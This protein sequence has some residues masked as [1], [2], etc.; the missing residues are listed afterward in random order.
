MMTDCWMENPG[1][2]PN[3]TQVRERLEE[4]TQKENVYLDFSFT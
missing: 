1:N 3:L 2:G 4:M